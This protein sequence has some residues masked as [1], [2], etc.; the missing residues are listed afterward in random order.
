MIELLILFVLNRRETTLYGIRKEII[1]QFGTFTVPSIGTLHPALKR[2]LKE[3]AVTLFEKISDGGKKFCYYSITKKGLDVFRD[4]FLN[5]QSDN[6]S[7]FYTQLQARFA[8]LGLLPVPD[9]KAFLTESAKKINLFEIQI[10]EKLN[11]EYMEFDEFQRML[12][13]KTL[14]DLNS[15]NEYIKN[16]KAKYAG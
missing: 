2:L 4:M 14:D 6:P 16:I 15:L 8:T 1:E 3:N 13:Y 9:R 5:A 7:L 10:K 12:L 11:D